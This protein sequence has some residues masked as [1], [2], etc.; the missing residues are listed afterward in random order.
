[1]R[2][3]IVAAVLILTV[4]IARCAQC[5]EP[6]F[7][8]VF[9]KTAPAT[10]REEAQKEIAGYVDKL[11]GAVATES[12]L[13]ILPLVDGEQ[14]VELIV[15]TVKDDQIADLLRKQFSTRIT[16]QLATAVSA[17]VSGWDR[18]QTSRLAI[19][20]SL[21]LATVTLRVWDRESYANRIECMLIRRKSG[22]KLY[23][24]NELALGLRM[25]EVVQI[26][27]AQLDKEGMAF[28]KQDL[29]FL[30]LAIF[31]MQAQDF[32]AADRHLRTIEHRK[33][34]T[35]IEAV[36]WT[37]IS[38]IA[39]TL[40]DSE[41]ALSALDRCRKLG[42]PFPIADY[43]RSV[44]YNQLD[45]PEKALAA[46]DR[47]L[48]TFGDD[49][50]A[51][52]Q[53][54]LALESLERKDEAIA[55]YRLGLDDT[56]GSAENLVA[57]GLLLPAKQKTEVATRFAAS[58]H[59]TARFD[60]I[61]YEFL[62]FEDMVCL[63]ILTSAMRKIEP[64]D[65]DLPYYEAELAMFNG[66]Y[67]RA[68]VLLKDV[69][70]KIEDEELRSFYLDR[71]LDAALEAKRVVAAYQ[72]ASDKDYAF[73]YLA[74][75]LPGEDRD[76]ELAALI[77]E[78]KRE[79][80]DDSLAWYFTGDMYYYQDEYQKADDAYSKAATLNPDGEYETLISRSR[81]Y[82]WYELG[83]GLDAY[84]KFKPDEDTFDAL[85]ELFI[86]DEKFSD[87]ESLIDRHEKVHGRSSRGVYWRTQAHW[88]R[89]EYAEYVE[90]VI[91]HFDSL[92]ADLD[93]SDV[94]E[95]G[96]RTIRSLIRLDRIA[97]ALPLLKK[98]EDTEY[99]SVAAL[100]VNTGL[101]RITDAKKNLNDCLYDSEWWAWDLLDDEDLNRLLQDKQ[102]APVRKQLVQAFIEEE[103]VNG[104]GMLLKEHINV[105]A[106]QIKATVKR[107]WNNDLTMSE[108]VQTDD[109]QEKHVLIDE[110]DG[111]F[112]LTNGDFKCSIHAS[113]QPRCTYP[114]TV[115][116]EINEL[117][118]RKLYEQ[119][120]A[121]LNITLSQESLTDE[122]WQ[123]AATL[124]LALAEDAKPLLVEA[125]A[126][127]HLAVWNDS[128]KT[129]MLGNDPVRA[130][131]S[132]RMVP[133]IRVDD[134]G[135]AMKKAIETAR[136]RW[137]EF[138][139]AFGERRIGQHFS[140]KASFADGEHLEAMW[141]KVS[142]IG[143]GKINGI[144]DSKPVDVGTVKYGDE[145]S[146]AVKDILD[147]LFTS[148][149]GKEMTGLFS[150]EAIEAAKQ[151]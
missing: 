95:I 127:G 9:V 129:A 39:T 68:F 37:F 106:D 61:A 3:G 151:K 50:D 32:E 128:L 105:S 80:P 141:I 90:S 147:W 121:T 75:E 136:A 17:T 65:L 97:D 46:A 146:V 139:E 81:V 117:R 77:D 51:L 36:K 42:K 20:E 48:K 102:A 111:W 30:Q 101:G 67:D 22:W 53:R 94:S 115:A 138:V 26:T 49:A 55:A 69:L 88:F 122:A 78:R 76:D 87:L 27:L 34:P 150:R 6:V 143:D 45:E 124:L 56:P 25:A 28:S 135:P 118:T 109:G 24:I 110:G 99:G 92:V 144:L 114:E 70:K 85:A 112:R 33:F 83:K 60:E 52:Y 2:I 133:V 113:D 15:S 131:R 21:D 10:S 148:P 142:R 4:E 63:E 1:M 73:E 93:E 84:G 19:A 64:D 47:Y 58:P 23:D 104:F 14:T 54:G 11:A 29:N 72:Q 59:P 91:P 98:L 57:L 108:S 79:F 43:L 107:L 16:G 31:S 62:Q 132:V 134:D 126:T 12:V 74:E 140:V 137:P 119:H 149:D 120:R 103:R 86:D 89:A 116:A 125:P 7:D 13:R 18:H 123:R 145:T 44:A 38:I 100:L 40:D 8:K 41:R 71:F 130:V 66:D 82:C 35:M 5:A 96:L